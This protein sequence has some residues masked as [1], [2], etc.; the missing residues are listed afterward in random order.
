MMYI[1]D[2]RECFYQWDKHQKITSLD[3]KVGD[4]I[5]FVNASDSTALVVLTY[6][7]NGKIVANVPNILLEKTYPIIAYRYVCANDSNY[8]TE[9]HQFDV[10]KRQKPD[11]YV[12]E[13][14]ET[15]TIKAAVDEA[16]R[17][18]IESGE[19]DGKSAYEIALENGFEGTEQ[20]W[21]DSLEGK[22]GYTPINGVDYLTPEERTQMIVDVLKTLSSAH[23]ET[24]L[25]T[26]CFVEP[27]LDISMLQDMQYAFDFSC[28]INTTQGTKY[29]TSIRRDQA[30]ENSLIRYYKSDGSNSIA[31]RTKYGEF[32]ANS[33]QRIN[34]TSEPPDDVKLFLKTN[35]IFIGDVDERIRSL[36]ARI[37]ALE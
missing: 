27:L 15:Y 22:D 6:E 17:V 14:T 29:Y 12:Y 10:L 26:W 9:R 30:S 35:G 1:Y 13:E 2:G 20:E 21:L 31:Y 34:V 7:Y 28:H 16:I 11:P 33:Y 23:D 5:H 4:E 25:G 24:C 18:L 3:F 8:T 19:V 32:S 36:E 37:A